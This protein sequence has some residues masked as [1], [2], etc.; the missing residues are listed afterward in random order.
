[1]NF[2]PTLNKIWTWTLDLIFPPFCLSCGCDGTY[3]CLPCAQKL[4][5]LEKQKCL[6]C[7][8]PSPFGRTHKACAKTKI[9]G[10]ISALP[11]SNPTV[12]KLI[13]VF[14][15]QFVDLSA[16]LNLILVDTLNNQELQE[17]LK[18]FIIIPVPCTR[19]D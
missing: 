1:M 2:L 16:Q 8:Q 17:F 5:R 15:Y 18:D 10:I 13:E 12:K 9:D 19:V 6:I 3:L 7:Q 11:Y 4:P 14:K